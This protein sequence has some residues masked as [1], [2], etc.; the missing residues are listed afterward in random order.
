M[1]FAA[2]RDPR[3]PAYD[4]MCKVRIL[5]LADCQHFVRLDRLACDIWIENRAK[6]DDWLCPNFYAKVV[7]VETKDRTYG[8]CS[9]CVE[10]TLEKTEAEPEK[11]EMK[12]EGLQVSS[13]TVCPSMK[14]TQS[15]EYL[16]ISF[17]LRIRIGV[18]VPWNSTSL[19]TLEVRLGFAISPHF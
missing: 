12:V 1:T 8:V 4:K 7:V 3:S 2:L 16:Y 17:L 9:R 19:V 15:T 5:R 13:P 11:R 6:G 18:I 10:L 14:D